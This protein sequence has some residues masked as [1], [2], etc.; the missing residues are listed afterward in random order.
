[1]TIIFA[2]CNNELNAGYNKDTAMS[3]KNNDKKRLGK[4]IWLCSRRK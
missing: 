4:R 1:M 2:N 3:G